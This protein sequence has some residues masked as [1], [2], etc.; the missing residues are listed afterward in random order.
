MNTPAQ[1]TICLD[2]REKPLER[3]YWVIRINDSSPAVNLVYSRIMLDPVIIPHSYSSSYVFWKMA[4]VT[5]K[6]FWRC[7]G[8]VGW[9]ETPKRMI[10]VVE[11][12]VPE[13][14]RQAYFDMYGE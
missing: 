7:F 3:G 6:E 10:R 2:F 9:A 13:H 11:N 5:Y 4:I 8:K 12:E 14:I 1:Q